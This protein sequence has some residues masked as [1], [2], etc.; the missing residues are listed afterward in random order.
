MIQ[1]GLKSAQVIETVKE[2]LKEDSTGAPLGVVDVSLSKLAK[3]YTVRVLFKKS[4]GASSDSKN[5]HLNLVRTAVAQ[6]L[7]VTP[8][9]V[10]VVM[11]QIQDNS[12]N[13]TAMCERLKEMIMTGV[14]AQSAARSGL[15]V[16]MRSQSEPIGCEIIISGSS[17]WF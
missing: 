13:A 12:I 14:R 10:K 15:R 7:G 4:F 16:I 5:R 1:H 3:E 9:Q 17:T 8:D 2:I 6:V 11:S